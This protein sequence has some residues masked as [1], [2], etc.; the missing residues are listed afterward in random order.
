MFPFRYGSWFVEFRQHLLPELVA[1]GVGIVSVLHQMAGEVCRFACGPVVQRQPA[2]YDT[3]SA[4]QR[5]ITP[6]CDIR[7]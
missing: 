2:V 1:S 4:S 5:Y 3:A 7:V 6:G